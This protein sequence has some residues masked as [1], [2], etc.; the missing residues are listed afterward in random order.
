MEYEKLVQPS[1]AETS[2]KIRERTEMA[3]TVQRG[4]FDGTGIITNA[5]MGPVEVWDYC[6]VDESAK[7]LLQAAMKQIH[8]S[9]R[10]YHRVL[11]LARTISDLAGIETI[12]VA[13]LA[14]AL[15]YRP[16]SWG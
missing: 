4:R 14:E 1:G 6:E 12:G 11:K 2:R 16:T 7:G 9:A 8:L 15:Q 3:R 5:E 13:Q 10:G